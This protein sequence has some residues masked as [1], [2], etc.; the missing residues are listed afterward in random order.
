[1]R[2]LLF[3]L[4]AACGDDA[5]HHLADAPPGTDVSPPDGARQTASV[6]ISQGGVARAGIHVIV[7]DVGGGYGGT[8]D[9]DATGLAV[10]QIYPGGAVTA[11]D[12]FVEDG[13][14]TNLY[15]VADVQPGDL[16]ELAEPSRDAGTT[17]A[18]TLPTFAGA[19]TYWVYT[20]CGN[21][22]PSQIDL[23]ACASTTPLLAV[24]NDSNGFPIATLFENHAPVAANLDVSAVP[25]VAT[26]SVAYTLSGFPDGDTARASYSV[27]AN[28]G[29]VYSFGDSAFTV[30]ATINVPRPASAG[31]AK[32][33]IDLEHDAFHGVDN[34]QHHALGTATSYAFTTDLADITSAT[35]DSE[36]VFWKPMN[37]TAEPDVA[38]GQIRRQSDGLSRHYIAPLLGTL[39]SNMAGIAL[40]PVNGYD[41]AG[42]YDLYDLATIKAGGGEKAVREKGFAGRYQFAV[43]GGTSL[44]AI[45]TYGVD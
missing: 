43:D 22:T 6:S 36:H 17:M 41:F 4:L 11:V 2:S 3:L 42:T 23:T 18:V 30:P 12:P 16:I 32:I 35:A 25:W 13:G 28:E 8:F 27:I 15:T 19:Q 5:V 29:E 26:T 7:T 10:A 9:T 44:E 45:Y 38:A 21:G 37:G 14:G 40:P 24:A 39:D 33:L 34:T 20:A 31:T 1:M